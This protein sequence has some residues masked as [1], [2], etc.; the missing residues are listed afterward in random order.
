MYFPRLSDLSKFPANE[1]EE[2]PT[3]TREVAKN[4]EC[5]LLVEDDDDVRRFVAEALSDLG[6]RVE[7]AA[8]A[9]AGLEKLAAV[10]EIAMLFTDVVLPGGMNG[11]QLAVEAL[12][13][14]PGLPVLYATGYTRNAIVHQGRLDPD[15]ELLTK[16]YTTEAMATKL[17]Q[18]LD[19]TTG[20]R[21]V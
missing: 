5:I 21:K 11:R 12:K 7:Q 15:V 10:P 4:R 1:T 3:L 13:L 19:G 6:Y 2:L 8:T 18:V 16:P 9:S 14:R 20:D 17:R